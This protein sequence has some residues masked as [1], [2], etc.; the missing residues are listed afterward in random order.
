VIKANNIP[1]KTP[2]SIEIFSFSN[3]FFIMLEVFPIKNNKLAEEIDILVNNSPKGTSVI[4]TIKIGTRRTI[5]QRI[6][7]IF[8]II[9]KL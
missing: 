8:D 5:A 2:I 1:N 6:Y 3:F 9:D 4:R 7:E